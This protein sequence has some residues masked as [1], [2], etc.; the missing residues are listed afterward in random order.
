M[1]IAGDRSA[2]RQTRGVVAS[3][4]LE[5]LAV[6]EG[7][8]GLEGLEVLEVLEVPGSFTCFARRW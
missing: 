5:A 8:E 4:V 2:P 7:L 1:A 6:L 3:T